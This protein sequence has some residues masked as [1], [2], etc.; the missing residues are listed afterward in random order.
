[1]DKPDGLPQCLA[2]EKS[3]MEGKFFNEGQLMVLEED[4][5]ENEGEAEDVELQ[6]IEVA[7][8]EKR[9]GLW[10]LPEEH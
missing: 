10:V 3:G 8:W 4:E 7:G 1:M 5:N 9:K 2:E 6:G